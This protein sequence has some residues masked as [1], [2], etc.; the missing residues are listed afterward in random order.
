MPP[1]RGERV[2]AVFVTL[3]I[4]VIFVTFV[5]NSVEAACSVTT[6]V[7]DTSVRRRL[8]G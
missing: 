4:F 2:A 7:S 6:A 3:V 8:S 1:L 5:F